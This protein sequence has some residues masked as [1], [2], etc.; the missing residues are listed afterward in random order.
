M[1]PPTARRPSAR[2]TGPCRSQPISAN[3]PPR[4]TKLFKAPSPERILVGANIKLLFQPKDDLPAIRRI[5]LIQFKS[6]MSP[7]A[8]PRQ[9]LVDRMGAANNNPFFGFGANWT[10]SANANIAGADSLRR[11]PVTC[12]SGSV[13]KRTNASTATAAYLVDTSR[14]IATRPSPA[15]IANG[16]WTNAGTAGAPGFSP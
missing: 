8:G 11:E 4:F 13:V 2:R 16:T 14:E 12:R 15:S 1:R 6:V 7:L 10:P 9:W 5:A 3:S